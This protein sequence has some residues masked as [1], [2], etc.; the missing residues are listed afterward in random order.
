MS[1]NIPF[2]SG[3]GF[4]IGEVVETAATTKGGIN[5]LPLDGSTYLNSAYPILSSLLSMGEYSTWAATTAPSVAY[6]DCDSSGVNAIAASGQTTLQTSTDSGVTFANSAALPSGGAQDGCAVDGSNFLAAG[7]T[8]TSTVAS[9][10]RSTDGSSFTQ[11]YTNSGGGSSRYIAIDISGVNAVAGGNCQSGSPA[12]SGLVYSTDSGVSWSTAAQDGSLPTLFTT[13]TQV[14]D[15]S[16]DGSLVCAVGD[17]SNNSGNGLVAISS[18]GGQNYSA[19]TTNPLT[20]AAQVI[21]CAVS[22]TNVY[23]ANTVGEVAKSTDSGANFS[24]ISTPID[25]GNPISPKGMDIASGTIYLATDTP[26]IF[27]SNDDFAT[28]NVNIGL[29]TITNV[30]GVSFNSAY[31]IAAGSSAVIRT[32]KNATS[33][34]L[35][36]RA[37]D[38]NIRYRIGAD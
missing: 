35:P 1:R 38:G 31:A 3:G 34:T 37:G 33:F 36:N 8:S 2:S 24:I 4:E 10:Y 27:Y 12:G 16:I 32:V 14:T 6:L 5:L 21:A 23:I 7:R 25:I 22:G 30:K 9:I 11:Q 17:F 20:A 28:Q 15:I 29:P 13:N 26:E 18:D 19:P